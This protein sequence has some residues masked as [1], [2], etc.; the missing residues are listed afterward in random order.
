MNEVFEATHGSS[1][2]A[3]NFHYH[4]QEWEEGNRIRVSGKVLSVNTR[5]LVYE[6]MQGLLS[7]GFIHLARTRR[8]VY[9]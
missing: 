5:F 1:C 7:R 3:L 9:N 2:T 6:T 4:G 8:L